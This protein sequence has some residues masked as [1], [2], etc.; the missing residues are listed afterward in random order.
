[1]RKRIISL[2]VSTVFMLSIWNTAVFAQELQKTEATKPI[3]VEMTIQDAIKYA[4]EHN[5]TI[6]DL[7]KAYVDYLDTYE[8]VKNETRN[9]QNKSK[10]TIDL[11]STLD[12]ASILSALGGS[13][14]TSGIYASTNGDEYSI[15]KGY[16]LEDAKNTYDDFAKAKE[17][18]EKLIYYGIEKLAYDISKSQKEI[19]YYKN[20]NI[21]LQ[22]DLVITQIMLK[23]SM[24]TDLQVSKAKAAVSQMDS[25]IKLL[26]DALAI[27]QNSLNALL[28]MDR[29]TDLKII[30]DKVE[31][32][33]VGEVNLEELKK[34]ALE[35]RK[36]ALAAIHTLRGKEIDTLVYEYEKNSI[37]SETYFE[38]KED[39]SNEKVDCENTINDIKFNVQKV[40]EAL[41]TSEKTYYDT[42]ENFNNV[43]ET[44]RIDK[45]KYANGMISL[46]E[47]MASN[48]AY[49]KAQNDLDKALHDNIIANKRFTAAYTI[50]DLETGSATAY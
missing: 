32:K 47:L 6:R 14:P 27:K 35:S 42:L 9:A 24:V 23:L 4:E 41:L 26:N 20:T 46:V 33:P 29:N 11:D 13:T 45:I 18:A 19:E 39:Y 17:Y 16:A 7:N 1:M 38:A 48:L 50:G 8:D 37:N 44:N 43:T 30:L 28:G 10:V 25:T 12:L 21:K 2:L 49:E 31:F 40:Y 22:K 36:D 3:V 5:S 34:K 15:Y